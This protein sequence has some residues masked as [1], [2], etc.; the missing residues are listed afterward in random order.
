MKHSYESLEKAWAK[1]S[2]FFCWFWHFVYSKFTL[3]LIQLSLWKIWSLEEDCYYSWL[4]NSLFYTAGVVVINMKAADNKRLFDSYF[5]GIMKIKTKLFLKLWCLGAWC[6]PNTSLAISMWSHLVS[7]K[8]PWPSGYLALGME[9]TLIVF[10]F[11][12]VIC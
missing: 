11:S 2:F 10:A 1:T 8:W 3:E 5:Q 6:I 12:R 4:C 7:F 9:S